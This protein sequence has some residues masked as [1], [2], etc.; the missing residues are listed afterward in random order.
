MVYTFERMCYKDIIIFYSMLRL[1]GAP[2]EFMKEWMGDRTDR[3]ILVET[4]LCDIRPSPK[5]LQ[6]DTDT[7]RINIH[8]P[9]R[10]TA[11]N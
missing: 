5:H 4:P 8:V 6:T 1:G 3:R 11:S 7:L 10:N 9:E 2:I